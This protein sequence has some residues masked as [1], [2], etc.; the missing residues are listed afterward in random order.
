MRK[1]LMSLLP[2]VRGASMA[3]CDGSAPTAPSATQPTVLTVN[4]SARGLEYF[5]QD[6]AI[7]RDGRINATL[8]WSNPRRIW[9]SVEGEGLTVEGGRVDQAPRRSVMLTARR[10]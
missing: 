9:I 1:Q 2:F 6:V 7:F 4:N 10:P 5:R 3:A 8:N